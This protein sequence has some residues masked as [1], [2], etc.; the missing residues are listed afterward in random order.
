MEIWARFVNCEYPELFS[1]SDTSFQVFYFAF[2][3][4]ASWFIGVF[5]FVQ[6]GSV[7]AG[8]TLLDTF[9]FGRYFSTIFV[10]NLVTYIAHQPYIS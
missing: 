2:T 1:N 5:N 9:Y 6:V 3:P 7:K 4:K 8:R 10:D